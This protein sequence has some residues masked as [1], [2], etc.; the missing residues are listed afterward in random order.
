M[1]LCSPNLLRNI[2]HLFAPGS[3]IASAALI[4]VTTST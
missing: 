1:F 3:K 2:D 4:T